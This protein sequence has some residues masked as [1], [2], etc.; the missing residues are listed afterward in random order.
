[1]AT[2]DLDFGNVIKMVYDPPTE[3]LKVLADIS[4]GSISV[5]LDAAT[6]SVRLGDGIVLSTFTTIGPKNALDV[7][8]AGGS[9]S[10][11]IDAATD[12]I[13]IGDGTDL[14]NINSDGSINVQE[15]GL[16]VN[17]YNAISSVASG[18]LT[19]LA[20]FTATTDSR[21]RQVTVSGNNIATYEVLVN[22]NVVSKKRTY[23]GENLN[24]TFEFEKG[25]SFSSGQQVLVRVIHN[26][27]T[28]GNFEAN[29][30]VIED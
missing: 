23:F 2:K 19:T 24:E 22:G 29:I 1:M 7:N 21:L 26:R 27:P 14:L 11:S 12:S 16:V 9:L 15:P 4:I 17:T 8:I 20:S 13:S 5:D 3:S 30:I 25:L 18:V 10:L 6:D 28:V